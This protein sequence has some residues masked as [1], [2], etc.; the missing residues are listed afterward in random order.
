[1]SDKATTNRPYLL[2]RTLPSVGVAVLLA[3][4]L[5]ALEALSPG[6]G[7]L[8][9]ELSTDDPPVN[10]RVT[11]YSD[12]SISLAWEVPNNRGITSYFLQR[13]KHDGTAFVTEPSSSVSGEAGG[14]LGYGWSLLKLTPDT[15]YKFVLKLKDNL[16]ATVIEDSV[17]VRTKK[18]DGSSTVSDDAALSALSLSGVSIAFSSGSTY[19]SATVPYTST[20]T[21]VTAS[22]NDSGASYQVRLGGAVDADGVIP[23]AVGRNNIS[24][25]VTAAD[26]VTTRLYTVI[27]TREGQFSND[28]ALSA[29]SLSGIDIG[30]FSAAATQYTAQVVNVKETTVTAT[31][32]HS[33]AS[34]VIKLNGTVDADGVIPLAVGSNVITIEVTAEDGSATRTY[35][36]TVTRALSTNASLSVLSLS[37]VDFGAYVWHAT[38]YSARV[39]NSI[40]QTAVTATPIHSSSSYVIKLGGVADADGVIA[41][42]VGRNVITVE[43]TA[44]DGVTTRTY[45]VTV[46]REVVTG[47]LSTDDPPLNF[48]VTG[49][50]DTSIGLAW[51]VPKNRGI[52]S[53]F[54]QRY[55][56]DGT[57]FVTEPFSSISDEAGGGLGYG[58]SL[59]KL[60]PDTRY[61]FVLELKDN[62]DTIVIED[63]AT[64]R[65]KKADGT[66]TVSDDAA[67]SA[68][69]LSGVS[70]A[71]SSG[72]TYYAA[73]V[74]YTATQTTVTATTN[75]SGASYQVR[76]GGA[77]DADGVIPLAVGRNNI[78]VRVTAAD[79]VTTRLYTV[80]VTREGQFSN[81]A[82][83]SA[84]SL[85]GIDIGTFSAAATQYTAQ[86]VNV[87]ETAVTAT[88]NHSGASRVIKLNGTVDAD[89]VIPLAVGSNVITIEVTAEDGSATR[90][91]TVTV[92]RALSTNASLSVLSLSNVDFGA[93]VWHTTAYSARV[94]NSITQ[95]AVTATPIH[96]SSSYVIKLGGVADA[97][98][99][100]ALAVGRN[101]ITVEVTAEDGVT[102]RTYTVT[103]IREVVT[104]QLSSDDPPVNF[105][106]TG[107]G[108]TSIGLAWEVPRNRGITSYFLQRYKHDGT[109]FVIEPFSSIS[110]KAGG[111]LGYGWSLG[112]L[113]PDT[114]YKFV[115]ELKDNLDTTV[116]EDSATVRTKKADGSSTVSDD[117]AL[118][119]LSLSGVSIAFSSG[120]TYYTAAASETVTQTVVTA[121][122][123]DPGA[124]YQVRLG[125]AV[126]ADGVVPLKVGRN[127]ISVRVTAADGVTTRLYTV[128]ITREGQFSTD[129]TLSALSLSGI[130]IGTFSAAATQYTAQVVNV[131]ETTVTATVNHSGASRVVKLNGTVDA[132]GVIP[133][134]V[135]SNVITVEV[136]AED[137][138]ATRTYTVTVTR[139]LSTNASLSVLSLSNVDFGAFVWHATAYS[140]RVTNSITQTAVTATPIHSSSS[141][142]I[143]LGGVADADGVIALAVGRNVITVEVTAEDG[144]TTRTYTVTVIREVVTGELS[145]DD[146]PLNFRVTGYGDT[147]IGLAWEVPKNRGITSYFLQRY[148]HDGTAFVTEPFSSISDKAGGGLGYGWSLGKLTPDT[149][150]KFVLEL[151]DNLDTIVI[152]DSATVRTKKA[153]GSSTVSDDAALSALS[154]SGVSIAFSSG[155]TYYAA[156]VS[157]TVTQTTVTASTNDPGASY[158]VQLGGA[159]DADG[160]IPLAVGRNN[161][162]VRVT[163]A[164]GVTTRIYTVIVTREGQLSTDATLSALSL[165]GIDIGAFSA[166]TTQYTAQ[167]VNVTETA[168][169]ATVNHSGASRVV[170]LNGIVDA[171]GVI[172]LAVGSNVIT[173]EVTAEDGSATRTYTVTVTVTRETVTGAL[174]ADDPPVN[175]RVTSYTDTSAVVAWGVPKNRGITSYLLQRYKHNG[176][177]F[178]F[179]SRDRGQT[180][181]GAEQNWS[182]GNLTPDTQ[183]KYQLTLNDGQG[184]TVIEAAATVRTR[185]KDL[186][187]APT[188]TAAAKENAVELSWAA[189]AGAAS[190]ELWTWWDRDI[191]WQRLDGGSLTGTS[192]THSGLVA[193]TTYY[194]ASR[195]VDASGAASAWSQYASATVAALTAPP[196]PA[197]NAQAGAG[198]VTLTWDAVAGAVRYELWA[199]WDAETG[200]QQ[201]DGGSLTATTHTHSGL[202]AG[203]TY[204]YAIRAVDANG[205][206]SAWSDFASAVAG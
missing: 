142:V 160:V 3:V 37:N 11:G 18:A 39:T 116:I 5:I 133:L 40:T 178:V 47:E 183:Y 68:L 169:T 85:S 53:Y 165:S 103:V 95:T 84:L 27:V 65:T 32:N 4:L 44:E 199:W 195:A 58:W 38:A 146:P 87:T 145:T 162:S 109:A 86:V 184:T 36:V 28:A 17:T 34:R 62:L 66:S 181:G 9:Q 193:G 117:A 50:G 189:V 29:L 113:T 139:A 114:R 132:D 72:S 19:Y 150:Y 100:I 63:S 176:T 128:I 55:K 188:L 101:V 74:P 120:T 25:R 118:S 57:A 90:T 51:E 166:A 105:R 179:D 149:R 147:S 1:M 12:T 98:G 154:L 94:T 14:G 35:T 92:T 30:T 61:K 200:W 171:D 112:K 115:L 49:Y 81:D 135:G 201:L 143:K 107:Y 69:S 7:L 182:N 151:K 21:T 42:A 52:T 6:S 205:A 155:T 185:K 186:L 75:D 91:Y 48:R 93:F 31:V 96:S 123:N 121:S 104:G 134:A 126:D 54:L 172:P 157:E 197:L 67:L 56:H 73:T 164:D 2:S 45:T 180:G 124:S 71:F 127:N 194:Y 88:V 131:T 24:V 20:Q 122:T 26:G 78:S 89:G 159:V 76:L 148:K 144:V 158:Q 163:A 141:Y 170:K 23:L 99:V 136:T 187:A 174:P 46:I 203:T 119:A 64:V 77:V 33:G 111:G 59:G 206:A 16:D 198:Q 13:Y 8:A 202:V 175:F 140:A 41:L 190:Y 130:D 108:D 152:E 15:R 79:G 129:A 161:I 110:D 156:A 204:Y 192:Y 138:S 177:A 70:I 191:G 80:I 82:T 97:D 10:F 106:V 102:T 173:V 43:V 153:D 83:L 196:V 125:G 60:T 168:V 137:G 167:V 22:T